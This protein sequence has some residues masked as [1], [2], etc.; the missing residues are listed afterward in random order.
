MIKLAFL[1]HYYCLL[2][3]FPSLCVAYY[4]RDSLDV[5]SLVVRNGLSSAMLAYVFIKTL[6]AYISL[7]IV[8]LEV[9]RQWCTFSDTHV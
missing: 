9:S 2:G 6:K 8:C 4:S 1:C 5:K 3:R 7:P